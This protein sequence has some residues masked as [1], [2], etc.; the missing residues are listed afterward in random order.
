MKNNGSVFVIVAALSA[1]LTWV[2]APKLGAHLPK[3]VRSSIVRTVRSITGKPAPAAVARP[4]PTAVPEMV[5]S[6]PQDPAEKLDD[7]PSRKGIVQC[8]PEKATWGVLFRN[9][10][11]EGLDGEM[12]GTVKG[13][14]FFVIERRFTEGGLK[15]VGNFTPRRLPRR[16]VL[17]AAHVY[18]F[19]GSPSDLSEHQRKCLRMY[20]ELLAE[21]EVRKE[22]ILKA[23]SDKSPYFKDAADALTAFR[24]KASEAEKL[25]SKDTEANRKATY[26]LAQLRIKV[27]ELNEKH[28]TWK[29]EHAAEFPTPETDEEYQ[30]LLRAAKSYA[31]PI[32]GMTY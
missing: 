2:F 24:R 20:Y 3:T 18:C 11:A 21:A 32:G 30:K 14:R 28:K 10:T 23:A 9:T 8:D 13:G 4:V 17:P 1:S 12:L 22:R 6:T 16:V 5:V 15:L 25:S 29:A 31:G 27:Q 7:L 26:E 19:T